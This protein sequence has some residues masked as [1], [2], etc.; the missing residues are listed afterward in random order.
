MEKSAALGAPTT[1]SRAAAAP[2]NAAPQRPDRAPDPFAV[3]PTAA[4]CPLFEDL[5]RESAFVRAVPLCGTPVLGIVT[6]R[7]SSAMLVDVG[8]K[9]DVL[10]KVP[11]HV[12][13]ES[14][15]PGRRVCIRL[16]AID[17]GTH[18]L[19]HPSDVSLHV[20]TGD[21]L[22]VAPRTARRR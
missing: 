6:R 4:P 15:Y 16:D 19:G 5:F 8:L 9:F 17:Y 1:V 10:V 22:G 20:A 21:F 2:A 12:P 14:T 3:R 11:A 18:L 13:A 7:G